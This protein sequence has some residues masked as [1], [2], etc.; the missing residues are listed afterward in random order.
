MLD[1]ADGITDLDGVADAVLIF[2]DDVEAGN[3]V[4]DKI[5]CA[6]A[7]GEAGESS[8]RGDRSDVDAEFL[9]GHKERENPDDLAGSAIDSRGKGAGLLFAGLRGA[10]LRT[11]RLDDQFCE[12][13]EQTIDKQRDDDDAEQVQEI[14]NRQRR[15]FG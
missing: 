6:K 2:E 15:Y 13:L 1:A 8:D 12:E 9:R 5:L 11:G 3:D 7:D 14:R 10:C 4:A